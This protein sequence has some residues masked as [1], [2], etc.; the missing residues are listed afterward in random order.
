MKNP[1]QIYSTILT[2][3]IIFLSLGSV[4][5]TIDITLNPRDTGEDVRS[6]IYELEEAF[7]TINDTAENGNKAN[8][9][10]WMRFWQPRLTEEGKLYNV[11]DISFKHSGGACP[12]YIVVNNCENSGNVNIPSDWNTIGTFPNSIQKQGK[13]YCIWNNP[14]PAKP[15]HLRIGTSGSGLWESFDNGNTWN[16]LTDVLR[17]PGMGVSSI[18]V[19]PTNP[20]KMWISTAALFWN[21]GF[22]IFHT[23]DGGATWCYQPLEGNAHWPVSSDRNTFKIVM[24]P[25]DP[26]KLACISDRALYGTVDEGTNWKRIFFIPSSSDPNVADDEIDLSAMEIDLSQN[27]RVY[28]SSVMR[29]VWHPQPQNTQCKFYRVTDIWN[30]VTNNTIAPSTDLTT[31]VAAQSPNI[32]TVGQQRITFKLRTNGDI[33]AS[34]GSFGYLLG[35]SDNGT[36]WSRLTTQPIPSNWA[37]GIGYYLNALWLDPNDNNHMYLGGTHLVEVDLTQ[38]FPYTTSPH[39]YEYWAHDNLNTHADILAIQSSNGHLYVGCDGGIFSGLISNPVWTTRNG[40]LN[41]AHVNG[42]GT[43]KTNGAVVGAAQDDLARIKDA[44]GNWHSYAYGDGYE[45]E[46]ESHRSVSNQGFVLRNNQVAYRFINDHP[47]SN[48][49]LGVQGKIINSLQTTDEGLHGGFYTF[50]SKN[51][52]KSTSQNKSNPTA[53]HTYS[54]TSPSEVNAFKVKDAQTNVIYM[55]SY[56]DLAKTRTI[57]KTFN[58]SF[59]GAGVIHLN[60]SFNFKVNTI[61]I[62]NSKVTT[63]S[64]QNDRLW[65]GM[66]GIMSVYDVNDNL[67]PARVGTERVYYSNDGGVT[68]TDVSKGLPIFP[69]I[70]L[71]Y[72][73]QSKLLYAATDAGVYALN[74]DVSLAS[75]E[76]VCFGENLPPTVLTDIDLNR[77]TNKLTVSTQGRGIWETELPHNPNLKDETDNS[78]T[79][80]INGGGTTTW[81][82]SRNITKTIIVKSGNQLLIEGVNSNHITINMAKARAII[83]EKGASLVI[84]NATLT[85]ECGSMWEGIFLEGDDNASQI[86]FSNQGACQIQDGSVIENSFNGVANYNWGTLGGGIIIASNSTF[87]NNRR[88]AEFLKYQR[89]SGSGF[90]MVDLSSFTNCTFTV[91]D[92]F[93]TDAGPFAYH[94]SMWNVDRVRFNGCTFNNTMTATPSR[95]RGIYSIDASYLIDKYCPSFP[96][97]SGGSPSHF[98]KFDYGVEALGY[99]WVSSIS[100]DESIFESNSIGVSISAM[101][102]PSLTRNIFH[103]APPTPPTSGAILGAVLVETPYIRVEENQFSRTSSQTNIKDRGL[104]ITNTGGNDN[105]VYKNSFNGL[106]FGNIAQGYN[107][108]FSKNGGITYNYGLRYLCN[109]QSSNLNDITVYPATW[110]SL[111]GIHPTQAELS[112]TN[113]TGIAVRAAGNTFSHNAAGMDLDNSGS[114]NMWYY[115]TGGSTEPFNYTTNRVTLNGTLNAPTCNSTLG[116]NGEEPIKT[117]PAD[118]MAMKAEFDAVHLSYVNLLYQHQQLIDDGNTYQMVNNVT[119]TWDDDAWTM[120]NNLIAESPNV[121]SIALMEATNENIMP[122]ALLL[123]VVLANPVATRDDG[124]VEFLQYESPTPMPQ[125]MIDIIKATWTGETYRSTLENT[126]S[127]MQARRIDLAYKIMQAMLYDDEHTEIDDI[128]VWLA[129]IGT[130]HSNFQIAEFHFKRG[131]TATAQSVLSAVSTNFELSENEQKEVDAYTALLNFKIGIKQNNMSIHELDEVKKQDLITIAETHPKTYGGQRAQN[132]LCFFYDECLENDYDIIQPS[133]KKAIEPLKIKQVQQNLKVYPNPAKSYVVFEKH[134]LDMEGDLIIAD[135]SGK[136]VQRVHISKDSPQYVWDTRNLN[137]G[138][139]SYKFTMSGGLYYSGKVTVIK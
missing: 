5:Q 88:S 43:N 71:L 12:Q 114:T 128:P 123:E 80:V 97:C 38:S 64:N 91:N 136:V 78:N 94:V 63:S 99:N 104:W 83:V 36:T 45:A 42:L 35:S 74:T 107:Q 110:P 46:Y 79:M 21:Y 87:R 8:F 47:N 69:I 100:I 112:N 25:T 138:I 92:D 59:N 9:H 62:D 96:N 44:Q 75:Q 130:L 16:N 56:N 98:E 51:I 101:D 76:W 30:S 15:N 81:N 65:V 58:G 54:I 119:E 105:I 60:H 23:T 82:I 66:S 34:C 134:N 127:V 53:I 17:L 131:N 93:P 4:G 129:K 118:K 121:S 22:G 67:V 109:T 90:P 27:D 37:G 111:Y 6:K 117:N 132:A 13:V 115:H 103:V 68:W 113:G 120:R 86:P 18:V 108:S 1:K 116:G 49:S 52:Y 29:G 55:A 135:V 31:A 137:H 20:D 7:S 124:F 84:K 32:N 85:N 73:E 48:G 106:E 126:I 61:A 33:V 72:D 10:K 24:H 28:I 50:N 70:K 11:M 57:S 41:T 133:N 26:N 14:D 40:D 3:I 89:V 102:A 39:G 2:I 122:L 139:Y 125:Y 19:H 77:C 95:G